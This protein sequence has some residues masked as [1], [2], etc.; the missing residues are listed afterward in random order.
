MGKKNK[1]LVY[2][3]KRTTSEKK[4]NIIK[5]IGIKVIIHDLP[6]ELKFLKNSK[7]KVPEIICSFGSAADKTFPM[8][9]KGSKVKLIIIKELIKY[10]FFSNYFKLYKEL[11]LKAKLEKNIIEL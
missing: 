6:V 1:K 9:Y 4:I 5:K 7:T 8:I 11:M 3:A 10:D 2:I